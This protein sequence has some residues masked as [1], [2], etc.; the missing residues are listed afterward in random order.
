M[1][2]CT[3]CPRSCQVNRLEGQLGF[4]KSGVQAKVSHFLP[5]FG[6]EPPISGTGGAGTIFF[7]NCNCSC[8]F[9]QNYQISQM[10]IGKEVSPLELSDMM[11]KLQ[12]RGCHNIEFVSPTMHLPSIL[13]SLDL[14]VRAGLS[15]P[16]V[17]NTNAYEM[18]KSLSLLDGI[19]D[20]Y[21]PDF[22]YA[23]AEMAERFSSAY[24][25]PEK[26][27]EAIKEMR[28]QV[29]DLD[30]SNG[31][32]ERGLIIRHLILPSQLENTFQVLTIIAEQIS[33]E[34]YLSLMSQYN[35]VH[36]ASAHKEI[37]R[38]L[39]REE[40]EKA[41]GWAV[42]LGFENVWYQELESSEDF[43]PDFTKQDPFQF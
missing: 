23:D 21:I 38:K 33:K 22:K 40:Y 26:A 19:V 4:C 30:V 1:A 15:I 10:G 11:L 5:H 32:A 28:N 9:C 24:D 18:L 41:M 8:I 42:E 39:S 31:T 43:L 25:Y 34:V 20:I 37:G 7:S 3:L 12:N 13:E 35:P 2:S 29:G 6:E 36:K 17:Y 27:L 16:I 14:A